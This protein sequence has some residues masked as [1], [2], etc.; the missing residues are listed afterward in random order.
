[1]AEKVHL[2]VEE[3]VSQ[4]SGLKELGRITEEDM[5]RIVSSREEFEYKIYRREKKKIDF[6]RYISSEISHE[7]CFHKTISQTKTR[8]LFQ[9]NI[10]RLFRMALTHFPDDLDLWLEYVKFSRLSHSNTQLVRIFQ[11]MLRLFP[12]NSDVFVL[13]ASWE[14]DTNGSIESARQILNSGLRTLPASLQLWREFFRLECL[15]AVQVSKRKS[16][17]NIEA[18]KTDYSV[19]L[20]VLENAAEHHR[21]RKSEFLD[22]SVLFPEN[23]ELVGAVEA[24]FG[25]CCQAQCS[26]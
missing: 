20:V 7:F 8:F 21:A 13:A 12:Y 4:L 2:K 16:E 3:T 23:E 9:K 11:D 18:G 24:W 19:A 17:R 5:A 22:V 14:Y 1:M 6:L 10:H 26:K 15:L 25:E